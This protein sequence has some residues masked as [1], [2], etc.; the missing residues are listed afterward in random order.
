MS[1]TSQTQTNTSAHGTLVLR[2]EGIP[3]TQ[4][5]TRPVQRPTFATKLE[6]RAYLKEHLVRHPLG[7]CYFLTRADAAAALARIQ[8]AA[9]R[10]FAKLGY[11]EGVGESV[12]ADRRG[13]LQFG[14]CAPPSGR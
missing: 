11:D 1:S 6:E 12:A 7:V 5:R 13:A 8:A 4:A 2:S 14:C 3:A 9:Y 10:I